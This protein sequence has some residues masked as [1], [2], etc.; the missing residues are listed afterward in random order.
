MVSQALCL[1]SPG[2]TPAQREC[3]DLARRLTGLA[4][5]SCGL[6]AWEFLRLARKPA[7]PVFSY[8]ETR[9][10]RTIEGPQC[11]VKMCGPLS[12]II[13]N[14]K[15]AAVGDGTQQGTLLSVGGG[16]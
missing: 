7:E 10:K 11:Q 6:A 5:V 2:G 16:M 14:G 15:M 8:P 9:I 3:G 12:K 1:P 4:Y 13:R